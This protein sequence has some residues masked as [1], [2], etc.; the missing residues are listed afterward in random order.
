MTK[1]VLFDVVEMEFSD[2]RK[3]ASASERSP[4]RIGPR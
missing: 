4:G 1:L 2:G 3:L